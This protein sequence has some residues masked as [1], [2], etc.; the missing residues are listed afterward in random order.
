MIFDVGQVN[1]TV[2]NVTLQCYLI[3]A[4]MFEKFETKLVLTFMGF[5]VR[6][7]SAQLAAPIHLMRYIRLKHDRYGR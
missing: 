3:C 6:R 1:A 5:I 2:G 7:I 4:C